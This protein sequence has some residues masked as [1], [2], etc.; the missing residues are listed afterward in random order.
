M[1]HNFILDL[2]CRLESMM[3]EEVVI[4]MKDVEGWKINPGRIS[5][6]IGKVLGTNITVQTVLRGELLVA[7]KSSSSIHQKEGRPPPNYHLKKDHNVV[8]CCTEEDVTPLVDHPDVNFLEGVRSLT[9]RH[10]LVVGGSRLKWA[11]GLKIDTEVYLQILGPNA[12]SLPSYGVG[13]IRYIGKVTGLPGWQ[14]GV[15]ITVCLADPLLDLNPNPT[16]HVFYSTTLYIHG[17]MIA[18][19]CAL[20]V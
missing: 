12:T 20:H 17:V 2:H 9:S 6:V 13:A 16:M 15:E 4:L 18:G 10:A 14:F 8:L 19:A 11:Q 3:A 7:L 1:F 5:S